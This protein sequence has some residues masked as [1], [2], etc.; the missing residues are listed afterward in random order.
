MGPFQ[1]KGLMW[2]AAYPRSMFRHGYITRMHPVH[3][4]HV[5]FQ[6]SQSR[7]GFDL[8]RLKDTFPN[9]PAGAKYAKSGSKNPE[10]EAS[11]LGACSMPCH[12]MTRQLVLRLA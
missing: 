1:L 4:K 2:S 3:D 7:S 5:V 10:E 12:P 6:C 11:H 8:A 9:T